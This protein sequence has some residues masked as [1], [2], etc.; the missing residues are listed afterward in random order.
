MNPVIPIAEFS[1]RVKKRRRL[2]CKG[3]RRDVRISNE[4]EPHNVRYFSDYWPSFETAAVLF[5]QTGDPILLIGPESL[6]FAKDRSKISEIRR[7]KCL[8]ES[9]NP[10]YPGEKLDT[11]LEAI[12]TVTTG[13][14]SK[15]AVA[16][17]NLAP[18]IVFDD[19]EEA[20]RAYPGAEIVRGMTWSWSCAR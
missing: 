8:R 12:Q 4:A 7:I 15:L 18:K 9:S 3:H 14:V 20:L 6:T 13:K 19:L 11:I 16:G 17:Y 10:E 5:G 2:W 1:Q